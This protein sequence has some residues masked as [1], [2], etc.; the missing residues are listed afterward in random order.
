MEYD[1]SDKAKEFLESQAAKRPGRKSGA[2]TPA[3]PSERK[4]GSKKNPKGSAG[5]GKKAPKITFSEKVVTALKNKV[6]EH[7]SKHSR[8]VTLGQLKKV[9]RRGAGAFSSSHRPGKS[10]GQWAMARVNT[11]L[12]MMRGGKVKKSY[13][14]ADSDIARGS[15]E[16]Y[17]EEVGCEYIDFTDL[18]FTMAKIDL[19]KAGISEDEIGAID[20]N[21]YTP[22]TIS[23]N[24]AAAFAE[25]AEKIG[26]A[27]PLELAIDAI[28]SLQEQMSGLSLSLPEFP[29]FE[30]PLLPIMQ[31]APIT[32]TTLNLPN[33]DTNLV[34]QQMN[35]GDY[36]RLTTQQKIDLLF[37]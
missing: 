12:K 21:L 10:R 36:N 11:F 28:A 20:Q 7:N 9:Y 35:M 3:K 5:G 23:D 34:S 19:L 32:P 2:Q 4:K 24:I 25:N 29:V 1:F 31:D 13:R 16:Y 18:N 6:K 26:E 14:A 22:M 15:E 30:N 27:N 33:I 17:N 8:K 37:G